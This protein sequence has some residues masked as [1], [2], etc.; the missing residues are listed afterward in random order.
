MI[1]ELRNGENFVYH[2]LHI[3]FIDKSKLFI[4]EFN[5]VEERNYSYHW[6]DQNDKLL[7]RWDNAPHHKN[8]STHPH[9]KHENENIYAS[10]E[11]S[12][13]DVLNKINIII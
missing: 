7:I 10:E 13:E 3:L 9:H 8:I 2:K 5:S 12:L 4:N 6:Q 1:L 11:I